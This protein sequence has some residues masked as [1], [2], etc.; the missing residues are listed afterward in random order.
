MKLRVRMQGHIH[1]GLDI[2]RERGIVSDAPEQTTGGDSLTPTTAV[3][4]KSV[5]GEISD[6]Q[7]LS[8]HGW[9][10]NLLFS[11][12]AKFSSIKGTDPTCPV[13]WPLK[14]VHTVYILRCLVFF[15]QTVVET[16]L[17]VTTDH[18]FPWLSSI[19]LQE[20]IP[21]FLHPPVHGHLNSCPAA[22]CHSEFH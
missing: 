18:S 15:T 22:Y 4:K 12:E 2:L 10:V 14:N 13:L 20:N 16:V 5:S 9:F 11:I 7:I 6:K 3:G 19:P 1:V 21:H 17:C 8:N